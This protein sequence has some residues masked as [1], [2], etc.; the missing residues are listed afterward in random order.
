[1]KKLE[2]QPILTLEE[3]V[4]KYPNEWVLIA[5][6]ELDENLNVVRGK[7]LA[8]SQNRDDIYDLLLS[9]KDISVATKYTGKIPEHIAMVL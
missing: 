3:I 2:T 8:N 6:N 1:M 4:N 9:T 7:V 5:Y